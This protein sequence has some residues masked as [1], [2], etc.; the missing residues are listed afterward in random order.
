MLMIIAVLCSVS[1]SASVTDSFPEIFG[2]GVSIQAHRGLCMDYPE[3]TLLSFEAAAQSSDYDAIETDVQMTSDGV[4]VCMHDSAVDRTTDGTGEISSYTWAELQELRIDGGIGWNDRYAGQLTV[5]TLQDYL[6]ICK[7]YG[8]TPYIELKNSNTTIADKVL[9][10]LSDGNWE[11]RC[12]IISFS[13]DI[14]AYVGEKTTAYP[15]EYMPYNLDNPEVEYNRALSLP[16]GILRLS[17]TL[18]TEEVAETCAQRGIQLEAWTFNPEDNE[19]LQRVLDM[20][21]VGIACNTYADLTVADELRHIDRGDELSADETTVI[22]SLAGYEVVA[23]NVTYTGRT[24]E[25]VVTVTDPA[26]GTVLKEGQDYEVTVDKRTDAGGSYLTVTGINGYTGSIR[27][28]FTILPADLQDARCSE[29]PTVTYSGTA[30]CPVPAISLGDVV[31]TAGTDFTVAYNDNIDAGT[32][33][34]VVT[35]QGNYTGSCSVQFTITPAEMGAVT[36]VLD[37]TEFTA[38]G[39]EICPSSKLYLGSFRLTEGE[40]Y[41]V[42]Y[43]NNTAP[44][45]AAMVFTGT[46]NFTGTFSEN[47]VILRS[48]R[49]E[50]GIAATAAG[51]VL[52]LLLC[53]VGLRK[54]RKKRKSVTAQKTEVT[55]QGKQKC[56]A[57]PEVAEVPGAPEKTPDTQQPDASAPAGAEQVPSTGTA[58]KPPIQPAGRRQQPERKLPARQTYE[59]VMLDGEGGTVELTERDQQNSW[60]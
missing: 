16:G 20:G 31:L 34:A 18:L 7:E 10:K 44:G 17:H 50:A 12:V 3:N 26:D 23:E 49:Q 25:P 21:V 36:A 39:S 45:D 28:E 60:F 27:T 1:V 24:C 59:S 8:K 51:A 58:P 57:A 32:A 48:S 6:D 46:G 35:G 56:P 14:L 15:L 40:D 55:E 30:Q 13:Y 9:Q 33:T 53:I 11:G 54:H 47:F 38:S 41:T 4:L 22:V 37:K 5:P 42:S 29:I 52:L 2:G 43:L 19:A